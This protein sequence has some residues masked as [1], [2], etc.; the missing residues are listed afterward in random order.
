MASLLATLALGQVDIDIERCFDEDCNDCVGSWSRWSKDSSFC[1]DTFGGEFKS[2]KLTS[3]ETFAGG[4]R[5]VWFG[6][7]ETDSGACAGK[8]TDHCDTLTM[9]DDEGACAKVM[10]YGA[11]WAEQLYFN[12]G[13]THC[14]P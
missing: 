3:P 13:A 1:M 7:Y 12:W 9:N 6:A 14:W 8:D 4:A 11:Q 5:V 10:Y 2:A